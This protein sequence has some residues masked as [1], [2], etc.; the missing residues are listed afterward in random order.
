MKTNANILVLE[1]EPLLRL[2]LVSQLEGQGFKVHAAECC[3]SAWG[4]IQRMELDAALFDY[5]LPDGT[6][7]DLLRRLRGAQYKWPVIILSGEAEHIASEIDATLNV[8]AVLPKPPQMDQIKAALFALDNGPA[9]LATLY[10]LGR[11]LVWDVPAD[12]TVLPPELLHAECVALNFSTDA[13]SDFFPLIAP[14]FSGSASLAAIGANAEWKDYLSRSNDGVEFFNDLDELAAMG[15]R[16]T[17][18][19]ERLALL[20]SVVRSDLIEEV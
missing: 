19:G 5:R 3:A 1:D 13:S 12:P 9:E 16:R 10:R 2:M 14:L 20:A 4:L 18:R 8:S 17:E 15:R 7:V 6:G 11:Y